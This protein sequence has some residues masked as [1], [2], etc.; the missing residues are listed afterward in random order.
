MEERLK[1]LNEEFNTFV[2]EWGGQNQIVYEADSLWEWITKNF[3]P[4]DAPVINF[5]AEGE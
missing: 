2:S 5:L 4:L 3:V 1:Q